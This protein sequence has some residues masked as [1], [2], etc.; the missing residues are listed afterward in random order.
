MAFL[1]FIDLN[2]PSICLLQS[3]DGKQRR[4]RGLMIFDLVPPP[5]LLSFGPFWKLTRTIEASAHF[6][7][8]GT[9]GRQQRS[10][11]N[12]NMEKSIVKRRKYLDNHQ[13]G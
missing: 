6:L 9:K 2:R 3:K 11:F 7:E 4:V 5:L 8:R 10:S 1:R 12:R 13:S